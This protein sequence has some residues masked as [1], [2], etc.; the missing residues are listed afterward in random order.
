MLKKSL[1]TQYNVLV[2][3]VLLN[4]VFQQRVYSIHGGGAAAL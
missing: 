3:G 4:R 2:Y 1:R